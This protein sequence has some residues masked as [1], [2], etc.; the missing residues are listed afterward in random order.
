M[1]DV[2]AEDDKSR[3]TRGGTRRNTP[4]WSLMVHPSGQG[5]WQ[6]VWRMDRS[7]PSNGGGKLFVFEKEQVKDEERRRRGEY[8]GRASER[9]S[10]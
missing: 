1:S 3:G 2:D 9:A 10:E 8:L 4:M 5:C 7:N 6:E